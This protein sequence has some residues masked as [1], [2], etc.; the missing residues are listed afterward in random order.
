MALLLLLVISMMMM[1]MLSAGTL[2]HA[3]ILSPTVRPSF[4]GRP[5][6]FDS[7][8]VI[9]LFRPFTWLSDR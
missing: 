1:M 9:I 2:S 5:Y 6:G 4:V 7:M 8:T 3:L